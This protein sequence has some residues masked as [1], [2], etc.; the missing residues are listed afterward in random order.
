MKLL[1]ILIQS[2][3]QIDGHAVSGMES[4]ETIRLEINSE[5]F[6]EENIK[7]KKIENENIKNIANAESIARIEIVHEKDKKC[8][9][10][11]HLERQTTEEKFEA[12]GMARVIFTGTYS[13]GELD[14]S[15]SRMGGILKTQKPESDCCFSSCFV[16]KKKNSNSADAKTSDDNS[17][18]LC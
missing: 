9:T 18:L 1:S 6:R 14:T 11:P 8:E 10:L 17:C 13:A 7:E 12:V 16:S 5:N 2:T 3:G 4:V 15:E